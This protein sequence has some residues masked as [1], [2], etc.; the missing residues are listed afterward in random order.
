MALESRPLR[1]REF[2]GG[3]KRGKK[4][5]THPFIV[6]RQEQMMPT[7]VSVLLQI[8][9]R[10]LSQV[11][12]SDTDTTYKDW[13]RRIEIMQVLLSISKARLRDIRA[14]RVCDLQTTKREYSHEGVFLSSREIK[15]IQR[16]QR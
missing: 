11:M 9:A 16:G 10:G 12:S 6:G 1:L 14:R 15:T 8:A 13:R 3:K 4:R 5:A 7:F 2:V